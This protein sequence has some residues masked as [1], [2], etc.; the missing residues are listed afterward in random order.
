MLTGLEIWLAGHFLVACRQSP[1]R[2]IAVDCHVRSPAAHEWMSKYS[3]TSA[4]LFDTIHADVLAAPHASVPS[5]AA[6]Q[7]GQHQTT[8]GLMV[9]NQVIEN[10]LIGGPAMISR[11]L[12]R[13]D[14]IL[15]V[16]GRE[17]S[18][19]IRHSLRARTPAALIACG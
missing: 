13:G 18:K 2:F 9:K 12:E 17:V 16:D 6:A 7:S 14:V 19:V 4:A 3:S 15:K 1:V 10:L 11:Q 8:V 5:P